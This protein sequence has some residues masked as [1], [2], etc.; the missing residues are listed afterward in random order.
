MN[1]RQ[2]ALPAVD[3]AIAPAHAKWWAIE[4][5]GEAFWYCAP[6]IAKLT[7]FWFCDQL[8]APNFG[9]DGDWQ[10]SLVERPTSNRC[11]ITIND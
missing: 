3:W 5:S 6:Q 7:G 4:E 11:A 10:I 9:F 1:Q 2:S 8:P